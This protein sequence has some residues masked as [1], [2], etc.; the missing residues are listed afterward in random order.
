[1]KLIG[2]WIDIEAIIPSEVTQIQM[3]SSKEGEIEYSVAK[4]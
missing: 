4:R 3:E 2:K 1:M